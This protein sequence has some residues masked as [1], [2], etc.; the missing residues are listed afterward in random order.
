MFHL[1]SFICCLLVGSHNWKESRGKVLAWD[2][3]LA[4]N[5]GPKH[6]DLDLLCGRLSTTEGMALLSQS[7]FDMQEPTSGT[8]ARTLS[9]MCTVKGVSVF[10]PSGVL[11]L[12]C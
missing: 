1:S 12:V 9:M 7:L 4:F 2:S 3:G 10:A 8:Q 5:Y 11:Q 6:F